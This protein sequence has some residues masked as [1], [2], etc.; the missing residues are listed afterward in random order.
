MNSIVLTYLQ[1]ALH[2]ARQPLRSLRNA[3][4][5]TL[6]VR[7]PL[8]LSVGAR[9]VSQD[10]RV[11]GARRPSAADWDA[12]GSRKAQLGVAGDSDVVEAG[13][14]HYGY[15]RLESLELIRTALGPAGRPK[16]KAPLL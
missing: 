7:A 9:S 1:A 11:E 6:P 10:G 2:D 14:Y 12:A 4:L 3:P 8:A 16:G 13:F 15:M 5:F